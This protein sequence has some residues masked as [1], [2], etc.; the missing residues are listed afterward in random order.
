MAEMLPTVVTMSAGSRQFGLETGLKLPAIR[1]FSL[2]R[3]RSQT[4]SDVILPW[5]HQ[6]TLRSE[7]PYINNLKHIGNDTL[8]HEPHPAPL[9]GPVK[10]LR[11][12]PEAAGR[13]NTPS[14]YIDT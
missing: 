11:D 6:K 5:V 1:D 9:P 4:G 2:L 10:E 13:C 14:R 7:I 3:D 8:R 12:L